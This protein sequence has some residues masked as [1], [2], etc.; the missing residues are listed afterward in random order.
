MNIKACLFLGIAS[1]VVCTSAIANSDDIKWVSQC[2]MDNKDEG[3]ST[4][5]V[6]KYCECMNNKMPESATKSI[7]QWEKTHKHE[8]KEC[9]DKAGW[10]K[11]VQE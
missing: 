10:D 11:Q 6:R 4:A 9:S 8:E 5:V 7:T 1:L 2:M 3:Q